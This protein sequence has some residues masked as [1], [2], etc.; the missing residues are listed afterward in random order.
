MFYIAFTSCVKKRTAIVHV[1]TGFSDWNNQHRSEMDEKHSNTI[2]KNNIR[3]KKK[4]LHTFSSFVLNCQF[5]GE[6]GLLNGRKL[7]THFVGC[8]VY[9]FAFMSLFE[10]K[11]PYNVKKKQQSASVIT[12]QKQPFSSLFLLFC[13]SAPKNITVFPWIPSVVCT[14]CRIQ[15]KKFVFSLSI[16]KKSWPPRK[17]WCFRDCWS[18]G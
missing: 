18:V 12:L 14:A 2:L 16:A 13:A 15:G 10:D 17:I 11:E 9:G 4:H 7:F 6:T 5:F 8:S 3:E 1:V